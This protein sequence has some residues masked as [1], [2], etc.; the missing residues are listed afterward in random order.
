MYVHTVPPWL[1]RG[2][3]AAPGH[4]KALTRAACRRVRAHHDQWLV[5]LTVVV[6]TMPLSWTVWL[7]GDSPSSDGSIM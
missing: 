7:P 1:T 3:L 6:S 5:K 2:V 4:G